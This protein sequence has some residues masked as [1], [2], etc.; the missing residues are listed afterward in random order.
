[1]GCDEIFVGNKSTFF[2]SKEIKD[3]LNVYYHLN[4]NKIFF[5]S[6]GFICPL[7]KNEL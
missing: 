5:E 4:Y 1:M 2:C 7:C 6:D 3:G